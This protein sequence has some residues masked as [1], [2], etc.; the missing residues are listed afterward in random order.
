MKLTQKLGIVTTAVV[1]ISLSVAEALPVYA[2][3]LNFDWTG[4][5]GYSAQG[6]FTYDETLGD[7]IIDE[8]KLQSLTV[9][10]FDPS[11]KLLNSLTSVNNG[12][13]VYNFLDFNYNTNTKALFGY[14]DVGQDNGQSTDYYLFGNI[15]NKLRLRNPIAGTI[16]QND[17][18]INPVPEPLTTGATVIAAGIGWLVKHKQAATRT[19]A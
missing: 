2:V 11:K 12:S 9:S 5:A 18:L 15:G 1:A 17:G 16:D 19:K 3:T 13:I 6:F 14:F 7:A 10:F 4:K 8:S